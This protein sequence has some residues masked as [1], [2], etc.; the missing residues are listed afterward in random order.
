VT[1]SI[2]AGGRPRRRLK[3]LGSPFP[4]AEA[5]RSSAEGFLQRSARIFLIVTVMFSVGGISWLTQRLFGAE[6]GLWERTVRGDLIRVRPICIAFAVGLLSR[7]PLWT[8]FAR[9]CAVWE[10]LG[11]FPIY[12]GV[13]VFAWYATHV[14]DWLVPE[15]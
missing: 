8:L 15:S 1:A 2:A 9:Q 14:A 3:F 13:F 10:E 4:M 11:S 5:R 6:I 12:P 7:I